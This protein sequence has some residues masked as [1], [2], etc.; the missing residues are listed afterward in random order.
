MRL[1]CPNCGAQYEVADDAIPAAGRDVQCSNCGH[2][3]LETPGAS[4][5]AEE[6]MMVPQSVSEIN[7]ALSSD[8]VAIG[9]DEPDF[10]EDEDTSQTDELSSGLNEAFEDVEDAAEN[11][12]AE[13]SDTLSD[14]LPSDADVSEAVSAM[15]QEDAASDA[16]D[17]AEE[18][19]EEVQKTA[20]AS[21]HELEGSVADILR[22]E[23]ER[24]QSARLAE[25]SLETQTD[26][27]MDPPEEE[28]P[29]AGQSRIARLRGE[30]AAAGAGIAAAAAATGSR[31][32]ALPDVDELSST[33]RTNEERGEKVA[34]STEEVVKTKKAGFRWG[35]WGIILLILL[36]ILVYLFADQIIA[37][38]PALEGPV[39]AYANAINGVRGTVDGLTESAVNSLEGSESE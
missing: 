5:A 28:A 39:S 8:D 3:W 17:A 33:L 23:A 1:I 14:E 29:S 38:V 34:P 30:T 24:E 22:E 11:A 35:F 21:R 10:Y 26:I 16:V 27:P 31:K 6:E 9:D 2:T 13:V 7:D 37:A 20:A 15:T 4:A 36:A 18:A 25:G 12:A 19:T 32:S